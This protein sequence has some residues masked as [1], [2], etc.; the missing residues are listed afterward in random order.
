[1]ALFIVKI[2]KKK[3]DLEIR[4]NL[5][6]IGS[7]SS[8]AVSLEDPILADRHCQIAWTGNEF[9]VED[10]KTA[11]GTYV[12]G[13]PAG[14]SRTLKDG[15]SI[16]FG[17]SKFAVA[18]ELPSAEAPAE[19]DAGD[20][21]KPA[22]K[23]VSEPTLT[24]NGAEGNFYLDIKGG[25]DFKWV[26]DETN[27][28]KYAPVRNG[29]WIMILLLLLMVPAMLVDQVEEPLFDPG[30]LTRKHAELFDLNPDEL[31]EGTRQHRMATLAKEEGCAI[32]H[33][34]FNRTPIDKCA[35]CHETLMRFNHPGSVSEQA[36]GTET[37]AGWKQHD[38]MLCHTDHRGAEPEGVFVPRVRA[39][40]DSHGPELPFT[41]ESC[42]DCHGDKETP[43][44]DLTLAIPYRDQK[45]VNYET[46]PHDR[47]LVA[48][49]AIAC[50]ECHV[51]FSAEERLAAAK[52]AAGTF[53]D[54]FADVPFETC[55]KC[56]TTDE[57]I[58]ADLADNHRPA[59]EFAFQVDWH[60]TDDAGTGGAGG[61]DNCTSCHADEGQGL[62]EGDLR[63][64]LRASLV[65]HD[66]ELEY[67]GHEANF[68]SDGFG[69]ELLDEE[70]KALKC[71]ECHLKEELPVRKGVGLFWHA[72]HLTQSLPDGLDDGQTLLASSDGS[73]AGFAPGSF[74][75]ARV[76]SKECRACHMDLNDAD[77]L[78]APEYHALNEGCAE[79]HKGQDDR[80]LALE[81]ISR[82]GLEPSE[83]VDFPHAPH[84]LSDLVGAEGGVL[85][86]DCFQCHGFSDHEQEFAA[87]PFTDPKASSC[88]PCH[89]A[90]ENIAGN[91]CSAC[92]GENDPVYS[93]KPIVRKD[94][95][96]QGGF[97]HFSPG[98][99]ADTAS[100]LCHKCHDQEATAASKT[101]ST[102]PIPVD[103]Q[104]LC[105]DCHVGKKERFHWR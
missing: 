18:I 45:L 84:V 77:G 31:T 74:D 12:N 49:K 93:G 81:W 95:P 1:M 101:V 32:C 39:S 14:A 69:S 75:Q 51:A 47:H 96:D 94:W 60:G 98:H 73:Q 90:H 91:S 2:K 33:D 83:G 58:R 13:L 21:A 42:S 80:A 20:D 11:T 85:T 16:V 64:V 62:R 97:D 76:I 38:C 3:P 79:C 61:I 87:L 28:G 104:Q 56:H 71:S 100:G 99:G 19:D 40:E 36:P 52:G 82:E 41:T 24:L 29:N 68:A 59:A 48:G 27:F 15:D 105:L 92:H 57:S 10:L 54:D 25:D 103:G 102:V 89:Q 78:S 34:S 37:I 7:R 72:M 9:A 4:G 63:K 70:G 8:C 53:S 17:V 55:Q 30:A 46:F 65:Q 88:L 50:A 86:G 44:A 6:D 26:S 66:Y 23:G 43:R 22:A 5:L 35:Q 67:R